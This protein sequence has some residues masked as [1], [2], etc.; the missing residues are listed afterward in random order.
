MRHLRE[1]RH[2]THLSGAPGTNFET[3]PGPAQFQVRTRDAILNFPQGAL[4]IGADCS[5]DGP[6]ADCGLHT[7]V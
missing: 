2:R 4:R 1:K 3:V 5:M 6:W 7:S